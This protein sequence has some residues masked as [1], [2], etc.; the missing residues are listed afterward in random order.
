MTITISGGELVL[1][2]WNPHTPFRQGP[3][4]SIDI[5]GNIDFNGTILKERGLFYLFTLERF[6]FPTCSIAA[7][8]FLTWNPIIHYIN[9]IQTGYVAYA[10]L[11]SAYLE[12]QDSFL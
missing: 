5:E 12:E 3:C 4:F 1:G 9:M 10:E 6:S 8:R 2:D 11:R 7:L